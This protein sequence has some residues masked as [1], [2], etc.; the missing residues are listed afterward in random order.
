MH[1]ATAHSAPQRYAAKFLSLPAGSVRY[2][3][4]RPVAWQCKMA[5]REKERE[6]EREREKREREGTREEQRETEKVKKLA[7]DK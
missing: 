2:S 1:Q 7:R 5:H 4:G 3:F 6:R